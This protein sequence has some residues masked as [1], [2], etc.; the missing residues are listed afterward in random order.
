MSASLIQHSFQF[1]G[2]SYSQFFDVFPLRPLGL[3]SKQKTPAKTLTYWHRPHTSTTR[4]P[5]L[6]IH[7]IGIGL[8]PYVKFLSQINEPHKERDGIGDIGIIAIE[9]MPISFR[10][11]S[12]A[13]EKEQM[14]LEIH[15]ILRHHGWHKCILISHSYG[16]VFSESIFLH[17][18]FMMSFEIRVE[19][20]TPE[21]SLIGNADL[22]SQSSSVI[23]SHLL[24]YSETSKSTLL[25][26]VRFGPIVLI[27][28]VSILLHL[29]DVAYN[30][31]VRRPIRANEHQLYCRLKSVVCQHF[32]LTMMRLRQH[33]HGGCSYFRQVR[34]HL[35]TGYMR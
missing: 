18:G 3:L 33:G 9:I 27:D 11:T 17:L 4:L 1:H 13:L 12:A 20:T 25:G 15:Q 31:T 16:Y 28:P 7:G 29:P 5:V 22:Q 30:F 35:M 14:C 32:Q 8:Y 23:S 34:E 19:N 6:F 26:N 24:H 2:L 21:I 10:I